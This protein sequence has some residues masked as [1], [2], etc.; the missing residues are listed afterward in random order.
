MLLRGIVAFLAA[1]A[2][3]FP[4]M[5]LTESLGYLYHT[6]FVNIVGEIVFTAGFVVLFVLA[7]YPA[8][9]KKTGAE[10]VA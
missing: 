1:M 10:H 6:G 2:L 8:G 5:I 9:A 3:F 4:V 7:I